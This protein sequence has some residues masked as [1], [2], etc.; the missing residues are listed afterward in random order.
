M[1]PFLLS[2]FCVKIGLLNQIRGQ[3][4]MFNKNKPYGEV[5]GTGIRYKYEQNGKLYDAQY[6]EVTSDGLKVPG[7][8]YITP[9]MRTTQNTRPEVLAEAGP[10]PET[11]IPIA[12][13]VDLKIDDID[14]LKL[15]EI[16]EQLDRLGVEYDKSARKP[17][18]VVLLRDELVT[19]VDEEIDRLAE[20]PEET[21]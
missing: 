19:Q 5:C 20:T 11:E 14:T 15:P 9:E 13:G 8:E 2:C 17:D 6:N 1:A 18:L 16:K 21:A 3:S 10:V 7:G 4:D 12:A